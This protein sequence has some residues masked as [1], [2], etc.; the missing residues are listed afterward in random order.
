MPILANNPSPGLGALGA[1][2]AG[3]ANGIALGTPPA[4]T[5]GVRFYLPTGASVTFTVAAP[6]PGAPPASSFT[7]SAAV[8]GPNWDENLSRAQPISVPP[9]ARPPPLP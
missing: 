9:P 2:P 5:V 3:S 4:G 1:V 8:P 7:V 6:A